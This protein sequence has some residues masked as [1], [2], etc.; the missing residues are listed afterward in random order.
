MNTNGL[1]QKKLTKITEN[2]YVNLS[3]TEGHF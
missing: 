2:S 1:V 3:V